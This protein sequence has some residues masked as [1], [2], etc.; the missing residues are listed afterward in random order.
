MAMQGLKKTAESDED[1]TETLNTK[2]MERL[3][4]DFSKAIETAMNVGV[5]TAVAAANTSINAQYSRATNTKYTSAIDP[6]YNQSFSVNTKEVKYQWGQV[7]KIHEG[8]TPISVTVVNAKT[9]LDI[10][11]DWGYPIWLSQYNQHSHDQNRNS[12]I[13]RLD[14]S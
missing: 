1:E 14:V 2:S 9:I 7:T 11:N 6:Y 8:G 4:T 10:F 5:A 12:Q 13:P 3:V